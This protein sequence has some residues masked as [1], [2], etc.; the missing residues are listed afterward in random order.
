MVSFIKNNFF[1]NKMK[2]LLGCPTAEPK[3]YCINEWLAG[4]KALKTPV[5]V[6]LVD[7][8]PTDDYINELKSYGL[9]VFKDSSEGDL[10]EKIA[11]SR[12]IIREYAL[13]NN[14]DYFFSLEQD[15]IP[16]P[17]AIEKLLAAKKDIISG[18][19]YTIYQIEGKRMLMPLIWE[20][21]DEESM[22]FMSIQAREGREGKPGLFRIKAC[23][24]GVILMK[25]DVLRDIIFRATPETYDDIMFCLDAAKCGYEIW[26]DTGVQCDHILGDQ[27]KHE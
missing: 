9:T 20:A 24:L 22:N 18:V 15:V 5:D 6:I 19:Y 2:I 10:K 23:G 16:P 8:S 13:K 25:I 12:N 7:N 11:R 26:A 17:D 4:I 3:K 14:Y 27:L 1:I 21:K